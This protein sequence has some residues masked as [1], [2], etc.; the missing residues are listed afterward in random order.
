MPLKGAP[1]PRRAF[2]DSCLL[3]SCLVL[4]YLVFVLSCIDLPCLALSCGVLGCGEWCV[5]CCAVLCCFVKYCRVHLWSPLVV[6]P[7]GLLLWSPL[8]GSPCGFPLVVN[9]ILHPYPV[10]SPRSAWSPLVVCP[11]GLPLWSLRWPPLAPVRWVA[12]M[13]GF[14]GT[15]GTGAPNR[16]TCP[17]TCFLRLL[18]C[19]VLSCLVLSEGVR[20]KRLGK[21]LFRVFCRQGCNLN[22]MV[23]LPPSPRHEF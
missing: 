4:F 16:G 12:P 1:V 2:Q 8:V 9:R 7:C 3:L 5:L 6:S 11:C 10:A 22:F 17:Q 23:F 18:S 14:P 13:R 21:Q 20:T 15:G 19:L